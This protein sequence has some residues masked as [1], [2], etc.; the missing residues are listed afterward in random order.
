MSRTGLLS[1]APRVGGVLDSALPL[2]R[3]QNAMVARH[4]RER[5][6]LEQQVRA[7]QGDAADK[8]IG[9][10][11]F[12]LAR[13]L[14][15]WL[16]EPVPYSDR[17]PG[18]LVA[19]VRGTNSERAHLLQA[20]AWKRCGANEMKAAEDRAEALIDN[21]P[22]AS[23]EAQHKAV[24]AFRLFHQAVGDLNKGLLHWRQEKLDMAQHCLITGHDV[25]AVCV[26]RLTG[27]DPRRVGRRTR[28]PSRWGLHHAGLRANPLT[29]SP[30]PD[31]P[32]PPQGG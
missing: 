18:D 7:Q 24:E 2:Q 27:A 23:K 20:W 10:A 1:G 16:D 31:G 9:W 5:R 28:V 6:E 25:L 22:A 30:A 13:Q 21:A 3:A 26:E 4:E 12:K 19:E 15:S 29:R 17:L 32:A 11:A 8:R 14:R